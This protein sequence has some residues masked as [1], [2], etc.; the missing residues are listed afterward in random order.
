MAVVP[1][2]FHGETPDD[3]GETTDDLEQRRGQ[4]VLAIAVA[5]AVLTV[6]G[7]G[8]MSFPLVALGL[9][10][11]FAAGV[12]WF[13]TVMGV[14]DNRMGC[15]GVMLA[16]LVGLVAG[17]FLLGLSIS[18]PTGRV[19]AARRGTTVATIAALSATVEAFKA[20]TGR[21]PT[22]AE[23]LDSL[24]TAPAGLDEKWKGPYLPGGRM[25]LDGWDHGFVYRFPGKANPADFEILS[26][27]ADGVLGTADDIDRTTK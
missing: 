18:V 11:A 9:A 8:F 5:A 3:G 20:D 27:G 13:L 19:A 2:Y 24:L 23:G 26:A 1:E 12:L 25:P 17:L 10:T 7:V 22:A 21:Y 6:L 15:A 14:A 4:V 16:V